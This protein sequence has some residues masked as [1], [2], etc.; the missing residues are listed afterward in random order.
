MWG[1]GALSWIMLPLEEVCRPR[2]CAEQDSYCPFASFLKC[3]APAAC[4]SLTLF[5]LFSP[6]AL[7]ECH[8]T[9]SS[10]KSLAPHVPICREGG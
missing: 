6:V 7:N 8:M 9:K 10:I 3:N 2:V 4:L 1:R 5:H